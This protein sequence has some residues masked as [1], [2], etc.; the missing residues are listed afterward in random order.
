M[1]CKRVWLIEIR[2]VVKKEV[3]GNKDVIEGSLNNE[4]CTSYMLH[5]MLN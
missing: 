1:G 2:N 3:N 4:Q 5:E